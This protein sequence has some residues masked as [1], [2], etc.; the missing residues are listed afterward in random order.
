MAFGSAA[1]ESGC[2]ADAPASEASAGA[3]DESA[4][5]AEA[6]TVAADVE[7]A[8][9]VTAGSLF[10]AVL[11]G[12]TVPH[13]A[14]VQI[15]HVM[16]MAEKILWCFLILQFLLILISVLIISLY[17]EGGRCGRETRKYKIEERIWLL[18]TKITEHF[19]HGSGALKQKYY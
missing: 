8:G 7:E 18:Y 17:T 14:R 3:A 19:R 4:G 5:E 10:E 16:Q 2:D 1:A 9:A 11:F 6:E 12:E 15:R 13:P